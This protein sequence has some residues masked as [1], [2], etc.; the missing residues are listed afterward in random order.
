MPQ[1]FRQKSIDQAVSPDRLDDYIQVSNPS[2]WMILIAIVLLIAGAG[3]WSVF[4]HLSDVQRAV[5]VVED[6]SVTCYIDQSVAD[7]LSAGD[8]VDVAGTQGT[9]A[10]VTDDVEPLSALPAEAQKL[11][12]GGTGWFYPA[13]V[14]IDLPDGVY[15]ADVTTRSYSP[16]ALLFGAE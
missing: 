8:A 10:S 15:E 7:D 4:G 5:L 12:S 6:D 14:A 13:T 16:I 3:V 1:V 2:V 9:V 11:A